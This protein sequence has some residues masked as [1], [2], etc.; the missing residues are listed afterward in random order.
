MSETQFTLPNG[1]KIVAQ[2]CGDADPKQSGNNWSS[3]DITA[4]YPNGNT[5]TLCCAD[6]DAEMGKLRIFAF[7]GKSDDA[8][9]ECEDYHFYSLEEKE[10]D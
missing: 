2:L 8:V 1:V 7:D 6:Y 3:I 10:H 9:Y 4:K 5:E